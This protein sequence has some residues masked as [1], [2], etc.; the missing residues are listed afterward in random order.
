MRKCGKTLQVLHLDDLE[1]V[2]LCGFVQLT[3]QAARVLLRKGIDTAFLTQGGAF[4]G[5]LSGPLGKNVALRRLQYRKLEDP[6]VALDVAKR[7]V[8]GKLKN[9]RVLLMRRQKDAADERVARALVAMRLALERVPDAATLDEARGHEGKGAA[10][11]FRA[12]GALLTAPGIEFQTRIRRPPPD[13]VN[14][15]LSFGYTLLGNVIQGFVE[16]AG[17]DPHLGSLHAPDYGR[18]SL[19]LDLMEEMRPVLVDTAVLT[20]FN[21]KTVTS[22]DFIPA[23]EEEAPVEEEWERAETEETG[24]PP[25]RRRLVLRPEGAKRWIL[26]FERRLSEEAYYEAQMRRLT[27][28]QILREQVYLFARHLKGEEEYRTFEYRV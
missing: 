14:I 23:G 28:R 25:R 5:R 15:L 24:L 10:D 2:V 21:T 3:T 8:A 12:F 13:P 6:A 20:A 18:P 27:Y 26:T 4:L 19:A 11:Y 9:Q 22:K 17:L 16:L 1:Q 7:L